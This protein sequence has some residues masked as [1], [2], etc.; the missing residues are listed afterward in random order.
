MALTVGL[1]LSVAL[2]EPQT[3][4]ASGMRVR[5]SG[6]DVGRAT[7]VDCLT[8][9]T[10][11]VSGSVWSLTGTG[12]GGGGAPTTS[13]YITQVP[14][15]GLSNEQ[16]LSLLA[17]GYMFSTTATGV[18]T[19]QTATQVT[20]AL[21]VFTSLLQGLVP[22][23]GGGTANFLRADGSW[24]VPAG[25][26]TVTHTG[27]ALTANA[28]ILGAGGADVKAQAITGIVIGNGASAPSGYAG[29]SCSGMGVL[30]GIDASGNGTCTSPYSV[31]GNLTLL[32]NISG[33]AAIPTPS[34]LTAI[35]DAILG[36]TQGAVIYR[37]ATVW[38]TLAPG[39]SGQFLQ[40][41]GAAANVQWASPAGGGT[42]T[43]TGGALTLNALMLGAGGTDSKV[44]ASLGT[45][46][47]VL[48]GNAA[49]V[50]SFAQIAIADL[51]ATGTPGATT[52]LRGDNTWA[53]PAGAV[54]DVQ[55]FNAG[56]A[57]S[58]PGTAA[59][60]W[61]KPAGVTV[62]RV[63]G[64]GSGGGGGGGQ[65]AAAG[66]IRTGGAGG[67]GGYC[68]EMT[69]RASDLPATVAVTTG[70]GGTPG[71]GGSSAAGVDGGGGNASSFGALGTW[72]GGGGGA[73]NTA[74]SSSGTG[75]GCTGAG[76]SVT[77]ASGGAGGAC[78]LAG[79][80]AGQ[81]NVLM[82][83]RGAPSPNAASGGTAGAMSALGGASGA[84]SSTTG[85]VTALA[86]GGSFV[87][88]AG[89]GA[90]GGV[91]AAS[92]GTAQAGTDGGSVAWGKTTAGGGGTGGTAAAC[93]SGGDGVV[94]PAGGFGFGG[95]GGGGGASIN[96]ATG[97]AGAA[98][99][100]GG[101]GGGGGGGG[102]STGGNAGTGG[103]GQVIV[104]SW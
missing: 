93:A 81:T 66:S 24:T 101:G 10:C 49:G 74:G 59:T 33:G 53:A 28:F 64:C 84:G 4:P 58:C 102:T 69:F 100:A 52:F 6:T 89:G 3:T 11:T 75:A 56:A 9:V 77:A 68:S 5:Q 60:C 73:G 19:T 90:G 80:A 18:V 92:P 8:G 44:L 29:I 88:G 96:N 86:G 42:V 76:V 14:D 26:G 47:T 94:G 55:V 40:T 13:T 67:G 87:S 85:A 25:G 7:V 70:V 50:P 22:A 35:L 98:G 71:T 104:V 32:A 95:A 78:F 65:G 91:N 16:A 63:F 54:V 57:G 27:G 61:T 17:S 43:A 72:Q 79:V 21:N 15:A 34:S 2:V 30:E 82:D 46:T 12:G 1:V 36:T 20:A 48:H 83:G 38:T 99:G 62:V 39:T 23:S 45:T 97:C 51:S 103:V 41:Q 37:N 31:Q